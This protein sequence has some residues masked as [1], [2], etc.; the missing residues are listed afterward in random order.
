MVKPNTFHVLNTTKE[1]SFEIELLTAK[2]Y[3]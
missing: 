2:L 1:G 3:K